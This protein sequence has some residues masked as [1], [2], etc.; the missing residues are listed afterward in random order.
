MGDNENYWTRL[1]ERSVSRRR[2]IA[3]TGIAAAGSAAILAG[4]GDDD[5]GGSTPAAGATTAAAGATTAAAG[6]KGGTIRYTKA[7]PDTGLDPAITVTN[8]LHPAKAYSHLLVYELST[9]KFHLDAASKFEQPEPTKMVFTLRDGMKFNPEAANGRGVTAADVAYS[10]GR[11]PTTLKQF[12]SE[13]NALQF[14]WM[15]SFE[16]PDEKTVII[17][18]KQP[19]ASGVPSLGSSAFAIVAKELAEANGGKLSDVKN[20]GAGPYIMTRRDSTGTKYERNP[21]YF[22]HANATGP[23]IEDGPYID[24]WEEVIISDPAAVEARFLSGD[25]DFL[26]TLVG[27]DKLKAAEFKDK[28]GVVVAKATNP[29][30]YQM[31]LDNEKWA[32]HPKLREALSLSIDRDKYIRTVLLGEGIYGSPVGPVFD[33]V[34]SQDKLK[35]YQKFDPV[36][37]KALWAEGK[38]NDVFPQGIRTV[39]AT[40]SV[41]AQTSVDFFKKE[42]EANLGVKVTV[43][44]ADLAAYVAV[45]TA[46]QKPWE[47]FIASEGSLTTIPDYNALTF[48]VPTGYGAIF[49]NE[50]LDSPIPETKAF[51][52]SAIALF[53]KQSQELDPVKRKVILEEIQDYFL[54]NFAPS[55]PL[56]VSST[57]YGAYRDRV[58]NFPEKDFQLG[59][60]STGLFRVPNLYLNA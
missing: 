42:I 16:T 45:A 38:G 31:M 56:P 58:K 18:L 43:T 3:G 23:F 35:T 10:Y 39:S 25:I 59:N 2:F 51:A 15:D 44:P 22:K 54:K 12:G 40:F 17:K 32:P 46:R 28:K 36:K 29:G 26:G 57:V 5:D 50:R 8:P 53:N 37:A 7:S 6:K 49:G 4:C 41:P 11:F 60:P 55:L 24:S 9:N 1:R 14:S 48:Y 30:N 52:E 13:V 21:N 33:S 19:Y 34:F 47:I 27:V 20:A